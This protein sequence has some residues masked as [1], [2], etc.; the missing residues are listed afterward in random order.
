MKRYLTLLTLICALLANT[1]HACKEAN[2][3]E[4]IYIK[5][6]VS[7]IERSPNTKRRLNPKLETKKATDKNIVELV[8]KFRRLNKR[9]IKAKSGNNRMA[10]KY[11]ARYSKLERR[12]DDFVAAGGSSEGIGACMSECGDYFPGSGGGNGVNRA[13]CKIGCLVHGG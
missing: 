5:G 12:A 4:W 13:A 6:V 11:L 8:S 2:Q 10:K 9:L 3:N 7:E 1:S